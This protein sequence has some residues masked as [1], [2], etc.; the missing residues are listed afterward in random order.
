MVMPSSLEVLEFC[1]DGLPP[2]LAVSEVVLI[3]IFAG[4][5]EGTVF[6]FCGLSHQ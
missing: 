4:V 1:C 3:S 2:V 5:A 6:A